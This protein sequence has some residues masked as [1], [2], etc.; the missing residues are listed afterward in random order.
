MTAAKTA[1]KDFNLVLD[2]RAL[3]D[4]FGRAESSADRHRIAERVSKINQVGRPLGVSLSLERERCC[5]TVYAPSQK[6]ICALAEQLRKKGGN[7]Q[8]SF[9][10]WLGKHFT[11]AEDRRSPFDGLR[12]SQLSHLRGRL[13]RDL[14][15][16]S[17]LNLDKILVDVSG[18]D[19]PKAGLVAQAAAMLASPRR[20]GLVL[21]DVGSGKTT[22]LYQILKDLP[23]CGERPA[24]LIPVYV[25]ST[26]LFFK[27][28]DGVMPWAGIPGV[29]PHMVES[30]QA[31]F[32]DGR[33]LLLID[34]VNENPNC[35]DFT[36]PGVQYFWERVFKNAF[37]VTTHSRHFEACLKLSPLDAFGRM[38]RL[39]LPQWRFE[40]YRAQF[41]NLVKAAAGSPD[42]YL[43]SR[44]KRFPVE[45]WVEQASLLQ[46]TPLVGCAA[47]NFVAHSPDARLPRNEYELMEHMVLCHLNHR[48][49]QGNF[50]ERE[51]LLGI[52]MKISVQAYF[53]GQRG[54]RWC[55]PLQKALELAKGHWAMSAHEN[56]DMRAA[57]GNLPFVD[58]NPGS[59][60]LFLDQHVGDFLVARFLLSALL[61]KD[62]TRFREVLDFGIRYGRVGKYY[63]LGFEGPSREVQLRLLRNSEDLFNHLWEGYAKTRDFGLSLTLGQLLQPLGHLSIPEARHFLRETHEKSQGPN[64]VFLSATIALARGDE[65]KAEE[66]FIQWLKRNP[67]HRDFILQWRLFYER[68]DRSRRDFESFTP[69]QVPNWDDACSWLLRALTETNKHFYPLRNLY[70]YTLLEFIKT[71]GLS[72]FIPPPHGNGS[73]LHK[74]LERRRLL[75]QALAALDADPALKDN[76]LF[77]THLNGLKAQAAKLTGIR[78]GDKDEKE[79]KVGQRRKVVA[80]VRQEAAAAA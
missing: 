30:L 20:G 27:W 77:Q 32:L 10:D 31:A 76:P 23:R 67:Q 16:L 73:G 53:E 22:L 75:K 80:V 42:L 33:L 15:A 61:A 28:G 48:V 36:N 45:K 37:L 51:A 4:I 58:L 65:E 13:S 21:G 17:G 47:A 29:E 74:A 70:V 9:S 44:L 72:P 52:L 49:F 1:A 7:V 60:L 54:D 78:T 66:S 56:F 68:H 11:L 50:S 40:D 35:V 62:Y 38:G 63:F 14:G 57:L 41:A 55:V 43:V 5:V 24:G 26:R 34:G 19:A 39:S 18:E 3:R 46:R 12:E 25:P 2:K 71:K 79:A 69:S 59:D 64:F 8:R 6:A